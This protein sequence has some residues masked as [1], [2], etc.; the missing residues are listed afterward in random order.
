[1]SWASR[2]W[3]RQ[4]NGHGF[5]SASQLGALADGDKFTILIQKHIELVKD[6]VVALDGLQGWSMPAACIFGLFKIVQ[7]QHGDVLVVVSGMPSCTSSSGCSPHSPDQLVEQVVV[8]VSSGSSSAGWTRWCM[9][10]PSKQTRG[11][12]RPRAV[13]TL[14]DEIQS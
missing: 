3:D 9:A 13:E 7:I 5:I 10:V 6:G 4:V 2:A 1:M 8:V 12:W 14:F 11:R